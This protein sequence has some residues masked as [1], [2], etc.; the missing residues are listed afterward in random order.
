MNSNVAE[1][2][3]CFGSGL[4]KLSVSNTSKSSFDGGFSLDGWMRTSF[5]A[6]VVVCC[7]FL[8]L[9]RADGVP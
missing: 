8:L 2:K 4:S 7:G 9:Q 3:H 6:V 5:V 1:G